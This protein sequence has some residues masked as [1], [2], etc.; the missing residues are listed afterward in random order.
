MRRLSGLLV[1]VTVAAAAA[2]V[3]S[4]GGSGSQPPLPGATASSWRGLVGGAR[5]Q[6]AMGQRML[7]VLRIPSLADRVAAAGGSASDDDERHWTAAA[8]A[9]QQQFVSGLAAKGVR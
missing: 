1:L 7:V 5:P 8:L 2:L 9:T 3:S 4:S 6:V